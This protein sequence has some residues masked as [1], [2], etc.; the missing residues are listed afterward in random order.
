MTQG[1]GLEFKSQ[2]CKKKKLKSLWLSTGMM[3]A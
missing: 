3:F 1:V 2:F